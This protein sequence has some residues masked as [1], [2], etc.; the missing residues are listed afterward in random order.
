MLALL[1]V[2][3]TGCGDD[4]GGGQDAGPDA[5]NNHNQNATRCGNGVQ[6]G[7]EGSGSVCD[8]NF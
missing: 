2:L 7:A 4:D 1:A 6:E 8:G 3:A 5:G